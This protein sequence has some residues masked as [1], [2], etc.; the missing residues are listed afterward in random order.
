LRSNLTLP[1]SFSIV[2]Q[3][4]REGEPASWIVRLYRLIALIGEDYSVNHLKNVAVS[5]RLA[6][7]IHFVQFVLAMEDKRF[8]V[9]PGID[10][11]GIGRA[12]I[13]CLLGRGS[14]QGASTIPE[15]ILKHRAGNTQ[16][17]NLAE[18]TLRAGS[19]L[20]LNF[21]ESKGDL[22]AEY[23]QRVYLGGS[24][25]GLASA[26]RKYFKRSPSDLTP[27][28]SFFISERIGSPNMWRSGRLKNILHRECIKKLLGSELRKLPMI[29]GNFFGAGA[30][31]QVGMIINQIMDIR[32]GS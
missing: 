25:Y 19:S 28:Q 9:H 21:Y 2:V 26:A 10:P 18:R 8:W 4:A 20:K 14:R 27:A 17:K 7:P 13:M 15:Q 6:T 32:N 24:C 31:N 22:L 3:R 16:I 1:G 30:K 5:L 12:T 29:Y 11:I 23:C